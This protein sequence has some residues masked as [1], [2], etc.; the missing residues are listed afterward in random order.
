MIRP[1]NMV[2][3]FKL[4][5]ASLNELESQRSRSPDCVGSLPSWTAARQH[6]ARSALEDDQYPP[7]A[8]YVQAM[9]QHTW[10][11]LSTFCVGHFVSAVQVSV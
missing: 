8:A 1:R 5:L 2:I 10:A 3:C 11:A 6:F 7:L 9:P 4:R